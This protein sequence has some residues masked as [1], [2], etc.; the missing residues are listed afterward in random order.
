M[1][2]DDDGGDYIKT[3]RIALWQ[4][5]ALIFISVL[6]ITLSIFYLLMTVEQK[7]QVQHNEEE[8]LMSIG[9]QLAIEPRVQS[10]LS[11]T[12][13]NADLQQYILEVTQIHNLDFVVVMNQDSIRLTHPNQDEIGKVFVG[14]DQSVA[15]DGNE[16][17]SVSEG[18]LGPSL[19]AFVPVFKDQAQVGVVALGI[20]M[21]TLQD[22]FASS[23][24]NYQ[25][26]LYLVGILGIILAITVANY[27]KSQLKNLEPREISQLLEERNAMLDETKDAVIVTDLEYNI[28]LTNKAAIHYFGDSLTKDI[29]DSKLNDFLTNSHQLDFHLDQEQIYQQDGQNYILSTAPI[30]IRDEKIGYI[31]FLKNTTESQFIVDQLANTATYAITLQNQTHDFMNK[32]HVIYGLANLEAYQELA[33]Y[34]E[35][36]LKPVNDLTDRIAILVK[37]PVLASFLMGERDQFIEKSH[38]F[39]IEIFPEIPENMSKDETMTLL[40]LYRSIHR[41]LLT[42]NNLLDIWLRIEYKQGQLRSYY[43]LP[44]TTKLEDVLMALK[45][46]DFFQELLVEVNGTYEVIP[47]SEGLTLTLQI[48]YS[49]EGSLL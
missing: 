12:G 5:L 39:W 37:N 26:A 8:L 7:E 3:I 42:D 17:V 15:I 9:R 32:L 47:S 19:R 6:I 46:S 33:I 1:V 25:L 22:L 27:L 28:S 44:Q 4:Q 23:L 49:E 36:M 43:N 10:A 38:S 34:L 11:Q 41:A 35:D 14:G 40:S 48:N 29:S 2:N 45:F 31:F 21:T 20:T 18:T 24:S 13:T 16:H 30:I